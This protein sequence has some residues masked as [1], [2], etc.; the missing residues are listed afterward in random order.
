M[1]LIDNINILKDMYYNTWTKLKSLEESMDTSE[2]HVEETRKGDK[3]L[4]VEKDDKKV[5]VH[6][7]YNPIREAQAIVEDYKDIA[8][9]SIVIFYGTGL[10]YHID[11]F[12]ERY[13]NVNYYIYEPIPEMLYTYLSNKSIKEL[14]NNNLLD[15]VLGIEREEIV[16]FLNNIIKRSVKNTLLVELPIHKQIFSQEYKEFS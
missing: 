15:I 9:D 12:L 2:I 10:G 3:T 14:S 8:D 11:L 7:K 1:L 13:P 16:K 4:W 5:Y 6:S